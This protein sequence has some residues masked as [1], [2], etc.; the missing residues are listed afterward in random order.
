M[1]KVWD[2]LDL[3][4]IS[5]KLYLSH[6]L[7]KSFWGATFC[8]I[9]K[10]LWIGFGV[11]RWLR[12]ARQVGCAYIP[13]LKEEHYVWRRFQVSNQQAERQKKSLLQACMVFHRRAEKIA[14]ENFQLSPKIFTYLQKKKYMLEQDHKGIGFSLP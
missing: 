11:L 2:L 12:S 8:K 3:F 14:Q 7:S 5:I 9:L 1:D 13:Q 10:L 4:Q 6:L